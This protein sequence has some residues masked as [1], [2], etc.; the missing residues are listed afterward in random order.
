MKRQSRR[1]NYNRDLIIQRMRI[2]YD[3]A[4]EDARKGDFEHARMLT[5]LIKRLSM[6]NRVR[7]P[8]DV[9]R[10]IC[11]NCD[12]PLIPGLTSRIR[13]VNDGRSSRI[14]VTCLVCGWMHRYPYK[15]SRATS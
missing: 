12:V 7:I 15:P 6:R 1:R 11:E 5:R 3:L 14:V 8:L 9:K 4:V 10:G 13:L 2:L